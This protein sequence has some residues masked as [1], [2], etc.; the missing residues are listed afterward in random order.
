MRRHSFGH[1]FGRPFDHSL[2]HSA[3]DRTR[4]AFE[5]GKLVAGLVILGVAAAYGMDAAGEWD[6]R[7]EIALPALLGG[8][9]VAA[10]TSAL[11]YALRRRSRR[12]TPEEGVA[13]SGG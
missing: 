10:L 2:R 9:C 7:P 1:S 3:P 13:E 8:L 11:T 4:H 12:A 6:V 5:P